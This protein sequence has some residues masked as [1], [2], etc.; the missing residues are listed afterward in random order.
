M[1]S[2]KKYNLLWQQHTFMFSH[3]FG[4][5]SKIVCISNPL[6]IFIHF[7]GHLKTS[8]SFFLLGLDSIWSL[9]LLVWRRLKLSALDQSLHF[10][11]T[12][13]VFLF[14]HTHCLSLVLTCTRNCHAWGVYFPI[15]PSSRQCKDVYI[16]L[17]SLGIAGFHKSM[18]SPC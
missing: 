4:E 17:L 1:V 3:P 13:E 9:S 16:S 10:P 12:K 7:Q 18:S 11:M 14:P 5:I 15:H 2:H 8:S 6:N